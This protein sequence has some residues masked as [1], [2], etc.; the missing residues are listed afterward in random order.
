[1]IP[2]ATRRL[3]RARADQRCEYCRTRQ[4]DEPFITYQVEHVIALQ[5]GGADHDGNLALACSP[6]N[7]HK[8]PNLS[9]IDPVTSAVETLFHPRRQSWADHFEFQGPVILGK[10][11]CGRATVR[12]LAMNSQVRID[13]RREILDRD[14]D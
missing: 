12:V 6:C 9:G 3:V 14:A 13:L 4:E 11:A 2:A 5:H 1:M 8:G 10:T 7:L